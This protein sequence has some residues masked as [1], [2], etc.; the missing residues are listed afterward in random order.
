MMGIEGS[1]AFI[2]LQRCF[3]DN[4]GR[5]KSGRAADG[6]AAGKLSRPARPSL[7]PSTAKPSASNSRFKKLLDRQI[8]FDH[9]N[10]LGQLRRSPLN[11]WL[12]I[13]YVRPRPTCGDLSTQSQNPYL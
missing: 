1:A 13:R 3:P 7:W 8:I 9:E 4:S 10:P 6:T 5:C 12:F 2:S 11:S